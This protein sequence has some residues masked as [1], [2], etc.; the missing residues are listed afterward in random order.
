MTN[1]LMTIA[2]TDY[3]LSGDRLRI[4]H[5]SDTVLDVCLSPVL[6]GE[7]A[8]ITD[9]EKMGHNSYKASLGKFGEAFVCEQFD[10]LAF[11]IE[12]P[13]KEF[14]NVTYLSDGITSGEVWRT[15]VSDEHE[16]LWDKKVDTNIPISSAY[17][18]LNSPD[19]DD[20][21]GGM[22]D[23]TDAPPHWIWNVHARVFALKGRD[24]WLGMSIPGPWGIGV[25]RLNMHKAR[26]N[27]RFEY[28]QTGCTQ[29]KMPVIYFCPGL[30]DGFDALDEHRILSEKLGLMDLEPKPHPEWWANPWYKY[31]DEWERLRET[32]GI[33]AQP[34]N[35]IG[36]M[37]DWVKIT[38]EKTAVGALNLTMEQYCF[39]LYG[40]YRPSEVLGTEEQVRS[41]VDAWRAEGLHVGHYIHPFIV[42]SKVPFY[43]EHPEAFCQPKDPDF[44]M[45]YALEPWDQE[46]PQY[47]PI[48]WTH[49]LGREFML[50][51]VEFLISS[52][53]DCMNYDILRS[54][55][56]RSPDPR[57]Y[58]F[59]DPDWGVGDKMTY[60]VQK[61]MYERA[62]SVKPDCLVTKCT[63]LDCYMQPTYDILEM[64]EDWTHNTQFWYRRGQ[65]ATRLVRNRLMWTAAWF[66]TRTKGD[67]Y[68]MAM[69]AWNVPETEAVTHTTHCYFPSWIPL[70]EK[71]FR[72]RKS[73]F[74]VYL[75]ARQ[76]AS[77]ECRVTWDYEHLEIYRRKTVGPL[78]GWYG[79]LALSPKCFVTYSETQA[80]V[81]SSENRL[82]W[83]PLPPNAE[84]E[85]VT[86]VLHEG[87]EEEVEYVFDNERRSVQLY[88]ED[89]GGA[90]F[91]Y[92]IKYELGRE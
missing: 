27:L 87:C 56:W 68:Y 53:P 28:L 63:A 52:A 39:R 74:H 29:G 49:P 26:F 91:Y 19:T 16:R 60:K 23:P 57:C 32:G 78:A 24:L 86:R 11:W 9:W 59:H 35:V 43:Q 47:A 15:F 61:L 46:N 45:D 64:C 58:T 36:K 88:I 17:A 90:V 72:R 14:E 38:Q 48:D 67:E 54:N 7:V 42:N 83:V 81:G 80:L 5:R 30:A 51:Q 89:C 8:P 12:T 66:C 70:T 2:G 37:Q 25:A 34:R 20:E 22:T 62:K 3:I 69:S 75:N 10:R 33:E 77:D 4:V 65:I 50:G 41:A 40:D 18:D 76:E 84:L 31:W 6:D 13:V 21:L 85:Q 1:H 71:R 73:G 44:L 55:N 79:A 92:R 82:D